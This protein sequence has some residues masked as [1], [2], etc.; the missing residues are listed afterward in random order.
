MVNPIS[1]R[2][3]ELPKAPQ[4][5]DKLKEATQQ[6]EAFFVNMLLRQT[7]QASKALGGEDQQD[8]TKET[9]DGWQDDQMAQAI[10]TGGGIGLA[11]MLYRQLQQEQLDKQ[12]KTAPKAE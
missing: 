10:T 6:F 12:G 3:S 1:G 4:Q 11:E 2:P 5:P 8:F 7:R 9:Y